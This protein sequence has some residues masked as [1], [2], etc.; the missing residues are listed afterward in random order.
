MHYFF[1]CGLFILCPK[2]EAGLA[3]RQAKQEGE[4]IKNVTIDEMEEGVGGGMDCIMLLA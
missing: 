1:G 2:S 4:R 3:Q